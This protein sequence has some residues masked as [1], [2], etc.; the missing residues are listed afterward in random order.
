[1][2][3]C[4]ECPAFSKCLVPYRGSAC[5]AL[6]STYGINNDPEIITNADHI[7]TI[8]Q[9]AKLLTNAAADG[10]P[11]DKDWECAKNEY[12]WDACEGC[13]ARWLQQPAME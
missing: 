3:G 8:Q 7:Q 5:D 1:M 11:P 12:G 9:L 10:C 4:R 2:K 6:R 13:W